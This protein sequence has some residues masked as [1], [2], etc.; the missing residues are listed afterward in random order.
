MIS[1]TEVFEVTW[2]RADAGIYFA[3]DLACIEGLIGVAIEQG[4]GAPCASEQKIRQ[5]VACTQR[6]QLY[7]G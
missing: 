4:Q 6:E 7:S 2:N 5:T 1:P 3:C